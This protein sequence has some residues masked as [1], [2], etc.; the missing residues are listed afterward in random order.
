MIPYLERI[1]EV[2]I[3]MVMSLMIDKKLQQFLEEL[4]RECPTPSIDQVA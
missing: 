2:M 1:L 4:I 3:T